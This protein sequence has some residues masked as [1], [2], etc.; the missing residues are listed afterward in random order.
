MQRI[1]LTLYLMEVIALLSVCS[2]SPL[3]KK[4]RKLEGE[5]RRVR[6]IE[7]LWDE[8]LIWND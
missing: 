6:L 3:K 7:F 1:I 5:N 8:V 2:F 4:S